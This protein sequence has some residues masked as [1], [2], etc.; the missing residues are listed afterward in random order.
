MCARR[1]SRRRCQVQRGSW[2]PPDDAPEPPPRQHLPPASHR[3]APALSRELL[4]LGKTRTARV[5]GGELGSDACG[6][7]PANTQCRVIP[8]QGTFVLGTVEVCA[9]VEKISGFRGDQNAVRQ[10]RWDPQHPMI[11]RG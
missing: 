6:K 5:L 8:G 9:L 3:Q 2:P 10:T 7:G 11:L 4:D 1:R